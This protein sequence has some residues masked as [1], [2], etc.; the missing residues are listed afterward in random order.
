MQFVRSS[1]SLFTSAVPVTLVVDLRQWVISRRRRG[2]PGFIARSSV[3][4]PSPNVTVRQNIERAAGL[5]LFCFL[6][7]FT[8]STFRRFAET[9]RSR[10]LTWIR[11]YHGVAPQWGWKQ[12]TQET[13]AL[14]SVGKDIAPSY[15]RHVHLLG[16]GSNR[17]ATSAMNPSFTFARSCQGGHLRE[18]LQSLEASP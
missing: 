14:Y 12:R 6:I 1:K 7:S 17:E 2:L 11:N 18:R 15:Q 13:H 10:A 4:S 3:V 8:A 5:S 9:Q 16:R